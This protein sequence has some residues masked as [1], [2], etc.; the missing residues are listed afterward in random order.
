MFQYFYLKTEWY[1][2]SGPVFCVGGSGFDSHNRR[3][4]VFSMDVFQCLGVLLYT[5]C[6]YVYKILCVF[7]SCLVPVTQ[8]IPYFGARL[9]CVYLMSLYFIVLLLFL[10]CAVIS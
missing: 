3:I 9:R 2:G 5:Y 8:A 1:N 7:I 10:Q 4:F 6:N